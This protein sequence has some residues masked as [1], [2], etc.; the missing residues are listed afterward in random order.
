MVSDSFV[1]RDRQLEMIELS[2]APWDEEKDLLGPS[3]TI[4]FFR[5][6]LYLLLY[7]NS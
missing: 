4:L 5:Y 1:V 2:P 7:T 6:N 3:S